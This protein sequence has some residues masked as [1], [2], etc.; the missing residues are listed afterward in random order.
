MVAATYNN[1]PEVAIELLKHGADPNIAPDAVEL[2]DSAHGVHNGTALAMAA[3]NGQFELMKLL[4]EKGADVNVKNS[5]GYTPLH[6]CA[7]SVAKLPDLELP[8]LLLKHGADPNAR[9]GEFGS[10][11]LHCLALDP[12]ETERGMELAE[13]LIRSGADLNAKDVDGDTPLKAARVTGHR[14]MAE[15]LR[16]HGAKE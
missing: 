9:G 15:F 12:Q 2:D 6:E 5:L 16:R 13:L 14:K 4:V 11:P 10:T 8:R 1:D 7:G 3:E